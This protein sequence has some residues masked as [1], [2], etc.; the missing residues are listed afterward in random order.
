MEGG[1]YTLVQVL[2]ATAVVGIVAGV[3]ISGAGTA[4]G[5]FSLRRS[6]DLTRGHLGRARLLAVSHRET[7]RVRAGGSGELLLLDAQGEVMATTHVGGGGLLRL[8]SVVIRPTTL[9]FNA[10][11]QAAP[12]S[13]YLFR[14]RRGVRLVINFLGRVRREALRVP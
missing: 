4:L 8:D 5:A 7:V 13:V 9:R 3:A 6:A 2:L 1:G 10:R 14:G 12:G 11:G